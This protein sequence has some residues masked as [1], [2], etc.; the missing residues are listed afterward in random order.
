MVCD[1]I[2]KLDLTLVDKIVL[3]ALDK[4]VIGNESGI[5]SAFRRAGIAHD[6]EIFPLEEKT[7]SQPET[8]AL[9]TA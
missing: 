4:F 5:K 9:N 8:V 2:S 3:I 6:V 1:A 7:N